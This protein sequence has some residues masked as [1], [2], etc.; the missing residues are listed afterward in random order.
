MNTSLR[1]LVSVCVIGTAALFGY[2]TW[3][4]TVAAQSTAAAA[5]QNQI[6]AQAETIS[7]I[8]SARLALDEIADDEA[9]VQSYFVSEG[10]IVSFIDQLELRGKNQGATVNVLS[11]STGTV[12]TQ[13]VFVLSLAVNGPFDSVLR[14]IGT[15]EY[16]PYDLFIS[17]LSLSQNDKTSWHATLTLTVGLTKNTT[18]AAST[19][20]PVPQ[21]P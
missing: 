5:L 21:T 18:S 1:H 10:D 2:G 11:V 16:A 15:I 9:T 3:Y 4:A 6:A 19:T 14:T 13:P 7:R 8:A 20:A 12:G 17:G